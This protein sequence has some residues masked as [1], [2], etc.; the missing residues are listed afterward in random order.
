[1]TCLDG[2]WLLTPGIRLPDAGAG[3]Q[4]RVCTPCQAAR[5]G[6]DFLVVGRPIT[7][8]ADP[9]AAARTYLEKREA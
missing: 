1:M 4:S 3:D 7:Q 2:F 9:V 5:D 8:A 6:S